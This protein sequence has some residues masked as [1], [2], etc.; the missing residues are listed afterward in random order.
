LTPQERFDY[1]QKWLKEA[2]QVGA[3]HDLKYDCMDWCRQ[4]LDQHEYEYK[5]HT[6][7]YHDTWLF[8]NVTDALKFS[9][10]LL[11]DRLHPEQ[12]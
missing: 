8:E 7:P 12:Y 6:G 10:W 1:K 9:K 4:R 11:N 2:V 5:E 3:P